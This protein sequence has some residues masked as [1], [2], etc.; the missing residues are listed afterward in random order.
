MSQPDFQPGASFNQPAY[1]PSALTALPLMDR[2]T[3]DIGAN[4]TPDYCPPHHLLALLEG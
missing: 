4:V 1:D 2:G 3:L